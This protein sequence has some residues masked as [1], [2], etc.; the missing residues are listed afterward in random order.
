MIT[1][2]V[3]ANAPS[4]R[5]VW[6]NGRWRSTVHR[7]TKPPSGSRAAS[8]PRLSVPFFTGPHDDALIEAL[9]TCVDEQHPP[10]YAPVKA[11]DHLLHKLGMSNT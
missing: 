4:R 1:L 8:L 6:T 2:F 10:K 5:Q 3:R 9:P 11:L 7:V